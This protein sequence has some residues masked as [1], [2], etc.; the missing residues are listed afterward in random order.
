MAPTILWFRRDLRLHDHP[1]LHAAFHA[2]GDS[3]VL[4]LFII[5]PRLW[6]PAGSPRQAWLLRSL[7]SLNSE[8][9]GGLAII[10]GNPAQVIPRLVCELNATTV[11][12]TADSGPYGRQRDHA[13]DDAFAKMAPASGAAARLVRTGSPYAIG[14]GT[15]RKKD[16]TSF[17]VFTPFYRAWK[18]RGWPAP[19][20]PPPT[21]ARWLSYADSQPLPA[22]PDLNG[23]TLPEVGE[24]AARKR[25]EEFGEGPLRAYK[26]DRNRPDLDATSQLSAH[27]KYGEIHPRTLLADLSDE[28]GAEHYRSEL[29]WREFY[30]DVLWH[31]PRTAREYLKPELAQMEYDKPG[32]AFV[33]WQHGRTGYPLVD[34]GMRQL[35][36]T[37]WMH[38]RVRMVAASFLVKD[39]HLDWRHGARHFL[40]WLRD[41]DLASNNHGW[42]WVA[43]TG[44]DAA[45]YFRV[46]NPV[47]QGLK[48]DP[49]GNYVRTWIPELRH[50]GGA[51]AHE[52]WNASDGYA[53]G[54]PERIV[55][56]AAER[57]EALRRYT[58][59]RA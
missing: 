44:T 21:D 47:M 29:A 33:A 41:G 11:H 48:F 59:A 18:E 51:T 52:P 25:W 23:L 54:Y 6:R 8:I 4:P 3:G 20:G 10:E 37:G 13:V 15:I 43:G 50:L 39:L 30:A 45:P 36:A 53:H 12:V 56:H 34:A 58:A 35:C 26:T 22:E 9:G 55:D 49:D 17:S 46:F 38:N 27:L 24:T 19:A 28:P 14:P 7:H 1:A 16:G 42:Q 2:A 31:A 40:R 57:A 5:D 32:Q